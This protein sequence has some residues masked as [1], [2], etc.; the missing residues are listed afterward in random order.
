MRKRFR[1]IAWPAVMGPPRAST[2]RRC[3]TSLP[4]VRPDQSASG[5]IQA[6]RTRAGS[7]TSSRTT[8]TAWLPVTAATPTPT[9]PSAA[10]TTISSS[11]SMSCA[12]KRLPRPAVS[13]R[14]ATRSGVGTTRSS[15]AW[16]PP[17]T[18]GGA[19]G[20]W[21]DTARH[22]RRVRTQE[23]VARRRAEWERLEALLGRPRRAARLRPGEALELAALYRRSTADLARAQRDWPDEP[24]SRY[25][26]GLV[27]HGHAAVYRDGTPVLAR[28]ATFYATTVPRAYRESGPFLVASALLLFG[29][30]LIAFL[31]LWL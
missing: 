16:G 28:V 3:I 20:T 27:A 10:A 17:A 24:I 5:R 29:P 19:S 25:L 30:A 14:K 15:P 9:A 21:N 7:R 23:F 12:T 1:R 4:A 22:H 6:A 18:D 31:A 13:K 8:A 26:N 11:M 2:T